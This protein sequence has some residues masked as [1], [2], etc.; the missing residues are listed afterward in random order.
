MT[1]GWLPDPFARDSG[2]LEMDHASLTSG[3]W[4]AAAVSRGENVCLYL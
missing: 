1:W 3:D 2:F 4:P